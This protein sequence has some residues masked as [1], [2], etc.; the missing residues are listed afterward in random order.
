MTQLKKNE[1]LLLSLI[2]EFNQI[3]EKAVKLSEFLQKPKPEE[4]SDREW[5]TLHDQ[6]DAMCDY[7]D[8]VHTRIAIHALPESNKST[9][10]TEVT[11]T[12]GELES[13]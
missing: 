10:T 2:D 12:L 1:E 13:E 6:L 5:L 3:N 7:Q 9:V 8:C 4:I 11:S